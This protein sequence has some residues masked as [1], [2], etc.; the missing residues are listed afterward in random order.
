MTWYLPT[1]TTVYVEHNTC[2]TITNVHCDM[3]PEQC[4]WPKAIRYLYHSYSNRPTDNNNI[5]FQSDA[6]IQCYKIPWEGWIKEVVATSK[7]G[8]ILWCIFF[9]EMV[10]ELCN[11]FFQY[12]NYFWY[13][14][15]SWKPGDDLQN[16]ALCNGYFKQDHFVMCP[17]QE[18][19]FELGNLFHFLA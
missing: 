19:N 13:N 2:W 8:N 17:P 11:L 16:Q 7:I 1:N 14:A 3:K 18:Q 10:T 9:L 15:Q 5:K 6:K 12:K 4:V